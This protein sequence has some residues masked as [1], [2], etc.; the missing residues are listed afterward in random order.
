MAKAVQK[1]AKDAAQKALA[2]V[3]A[4][5]RAHLERFVQ[6]RWTISIVCFYLPALYM[7]DTI[8]GWVGLD[9]LL[10][11]VDDALLGLIVFQLLAELYRRAKA[12]LGFGPPP[13]LP[14]EHNPPADDAGKEA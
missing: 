1:A 8:M 3:Q 14:A 12:F 13:T 10:L 11:L 9:T 6:G 2:P 7:L 5:L 4:G